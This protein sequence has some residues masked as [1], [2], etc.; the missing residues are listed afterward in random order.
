MPRILLK[1]EYLGTNYH[2]WQRQLGVS[3]IQETIEA[4]LFQFLEERVVIHAAGR[5][6]KGV[7]ATGQVIHFDTSISR[8]IHAY[9]FGLNHFL[10]FDIR[11]LEAKE[12]E[13]N[14]HAR[15][16]A[17]S[18]RYEM[19]ILNR[20]VASSIL[21]DRVLW[22]PT[23]LDEKKM[24]DGAN[25]LIGEHDFSSFRGADCQAK[26]PVKN[27]H[28]CNIQRC[29]T[30]IVMNI[31]ASGF[32]HNMVRNITGMLIKIGDGKKPSVWAKEVL[33][34]KQK[35]VGG[36]TVA[37]EGLYLVEIAYKKVDGRN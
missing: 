19:R 25:Y 7:H 21:A 9:V 20:P 18:R 22:H 24:Q 28:F 32:L 17:I 12:V 31:Q 16:D 2:G 27:L 6:D 10:P 34:A 23:F 14:F 36:K 29:D 4:A 13:A 33:K 8:P 26:S 15:F 3:S 11:I 37:P 1:V 30:L 35:E 5:T